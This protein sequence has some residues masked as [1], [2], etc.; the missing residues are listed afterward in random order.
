M[1]FKESQLSLLM[2][3]L[4]VAFA[5]HQIILDHRSAPIDHRLVYV[6]Q[7]FEKVFKRTTKD[8]MG[9][10]A[11]EIPIV[12]DWGFDWLKLYGMVDALK[13]EALSFESYIEPLKRWYEIVAYTHQKGFFATIFRDIAEHKQIESELKESREEYK[14]IV[15]S[16]NEALYIHDFKGNMLNV[17]DNACKTLGYKSEELLN[18]T[19]A[20]LNSE[21]DNLKMRHRLKRL[22]EQGYTQFEGEFLRKDGAKVPGEVSAKIVSWEGEGVIQSL[23]RDITARKKIEEK[24]QKRERHLAL[25][26]KSIGDGVI[27]TDRYGQITSMNL[28]AESITQWRE[29]EAIGRLF[30]EVMSL[31]DT[32]TERPVIIPLET[33]METGKMTK[34]DRN[35][36]LIAKDGAKRK[37]LERAGPIRNEKKEILG[38]VIVFSDITKQSQL[39]EEIKEKERLNTK[40]LSSLPHPVMLI[41]AHDRVILTANQAAINMGVRIG[42]QCWQEFTKGKYINQEKER[43]TKRKTSAYGV[44]CHFCQG[45]ECLATESV[46]N[47]PMLNLLDR[48]WDVYWIRVDEETYLHYA[49]DITEKRRG[50]LALKEHTDRVER[51]NQRLDQEINKA[52]T[53]HEKTL[54]RATPNI[55]GLDLYAYYQPAS[56]I[57]GDFYNF[58]V[59]QHQLLFYI[60]DVSGHGLDAAMMSAFVKNTITTYINLLPEPMALEPNALLNFIVKQYS[61][62]EYPEDYFVTILVGIMDPIQQTLTYSSAGMHVPPLSI[63]NRELIELPA[64]NLPISTTIPPEELCYHNERFH[65]PSETTLIFSTDGLTEEMVGEKTFG[66]IYPSQIR[67]KSYLPPGAIGEIIN[68]SF[69][70]STGS[71]IGHDDITYLI[72]QTSPQQEYPQLYFEIHSNLKEVENA[73][74]RALSFVAPYRIDMDS[75]KM[76][77]HELLINAIE[78]GNRFSPEKKVKVHAEIQ[79]RFLKICIEDEGEGFDWRK[80]ALQTEGEL[81]T[82]KEEVEERGRGL[83]YV[84]TK[85]A[86]N[87]FYY[88]NET[89]TKA[90]FVILR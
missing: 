16:I 48:I 40:I 61:Q 78:H 82:I 59:L 49:I 75:L 46:K 55:R 50:E 5:Y 89:G 9:K 30:G 8:M 11:A 69:R 66:E 68:Q 65:I 76:A 87:Y 21:A 62:E 70:A 72:L 19:L 53:V 13:G 83:G 88:S 56:E 38:F 31:I 60:S 12:K 15:E 73:K 20:E 25:T 42:G 35:I 86:T 7:S 52:K 14:S 44:Q 34:I 1:C 4:P 58:F 37:I 41:R 64:G 3:N 10:R 45:N 33:M 39:E 71:L 57:G 84:V 24:L 6:N 36:T 32:K 63:N 17:N 79:D 77:L 27:T 54:P 67:N 80:R 22:M 43:E 26:L 29:E 85:E 28:A 81:D 2:D 47:N 18:L 74:E 51:A 23:A 90:T